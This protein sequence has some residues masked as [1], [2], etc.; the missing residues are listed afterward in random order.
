METNVEKVWIDDTAVYIQTGDG[1]VFSE[2][3]DDYPRLRNATKEQRASFRCGNVGIRWEEIDED[4]SFAGFMQKKHETNNKL[5]SIFKEH[6][7]LN[8]SAFSRSI[9]VPQSVMA[10]Y[11]CGIKKPSRERLKQIEAKL[12]ILGNSLAEIKL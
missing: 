3:F 12:K 8:V 6:P 11:L 5:Y 9:G 2:R 7:E 1:K 4:L 10:A